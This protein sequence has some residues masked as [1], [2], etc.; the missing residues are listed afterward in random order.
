MKSKLGFLLTLI[1]LIGLGFAV[2]RLM[3]GRSPKE[4][5]LRVDSAPTVS[6][7]LDNQH[8]G[9]T[10]FRSKVAAGEHT[11]K[12][13][14]DSATA[15]IAGWQGKVVISTS[16]LTFINASLAESEFASAVDI[17]WLEK[18]SGKHSE[19]SV[20]T[21]PDGATVHIDD[22]TKGSTPLNLQ[23]ISVGDHNM[24]VTSPGFATR[25]VKIKTAAGYKLIASLKLALFDGMTAEEATASATP[26]AQ[27]KGTPKPTA[28]QEASQRQNP[29]PKPYA[30]IKETP[31]GYLRVRMEPTTVATIAGQVK[32]GEQYTIL[33]T[34]ED[35]KGTPWYQV[36]FDGTNKGWISSQY[37]E[38]VE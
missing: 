37:A 23:D 34:K 32:P 5:E 18:I 33:E 15:P 13:V 10:P 35:V 29:P 21:N 9:R 20:I 1:V 19:L 14:T 22:Q 11:V 25:T 36:V 6:V 31:I 24:T 2:V 28:K 26:S 12:L 30:V 27:I 4:G 16:L 3:K 8:L 17:L 7:F 38:K